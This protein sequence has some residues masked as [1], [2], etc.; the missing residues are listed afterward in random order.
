LKIKM[1]FWSFHGKLSAAGA[2]STTPGRRGDPPALAPHRPEK[3]RACESGAIALFLDE[4]KSRPW[5]R[6]G[7]IGLGMVLG[8]FLLF[9]FFFFLF[10]RLLF[11]HWVWA[12][13]FGV[14]AAVLSRLTVQRGPR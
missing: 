11:S 8:R 3:W 6:G 12:W 7:K 9:L 13:V 14:W 10:T 1:S 2:L 5:A 4:K